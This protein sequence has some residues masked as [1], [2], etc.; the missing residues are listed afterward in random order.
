MTQ[1]DPQNM[2]CE[3]RT[4]AV[5]TE[6]RL[7]SQEQSIALSNEVGDEVVLL[8]DTDSELMTATVLGAERRRA[9]GAL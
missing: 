4:L 3:P 5:S 6:Q 7:L 1:H 9:H 8:L 2:A